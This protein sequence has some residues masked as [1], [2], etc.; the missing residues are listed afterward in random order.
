MLFPKE[1][2]I[3]EDLVLYRSKFGS[4]WIIGGHCVQLAL[5][6]TKINHFALNIAH[7]NIQVK[8][9][10]ESVVKRSIVAGM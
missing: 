6:S 1:E 9:N 7:S 5:E 4:G 2:K 8:S 10:L 3:V